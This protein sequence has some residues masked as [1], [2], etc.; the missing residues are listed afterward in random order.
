MT[1][2]E[3]RRMAIHQ[4]GH[5]V[6]QALVGR[7]RFSVYRLAI[8][9]EAN[10]DWP[11]HEARGAA[12]LDRE[13]MLNIYEFGLVTLAGIAAEERYL[14]SRP[15]EAEP[16]V[17]LSDLAEWRK[18]AAQVFG[19]AGRINLVSLNVMRRLHAWF[20]D[21][22]VWQVTERLADA[23]LEQGELR[24]GELRRILAGLPAGPTS[25]ATGYGSP[26]RD[27]R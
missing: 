15:P 5:A 20:A 4:A 17:A 8:G 12:T 24:Q 27:P 16:L 23:L 1:T 7:D 2:P 6:A 25:Y 22:G 13:T 11:G 19:S 18:A 10:R 14:A 3:P 21:P 9:I 26:A